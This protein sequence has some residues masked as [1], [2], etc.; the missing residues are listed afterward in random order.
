MATIKWDEEGKKLYEAGTSKGVLFV[1]DGAS[2]WKTGVPWNG[3]I[4][5][6]QN[7][8][9][10]ESNP[11]Y[12]NND[13][14]IIMTS[15]ENFKGNI[16]AYTYPDEFAECDGTKEIA[17]GVLLGQQGRIPFCLVYNTILG[18]DILG[19]DYGEKMHFIYNAK[20]ATSN[21][22]YSTINNDLDALTF[23]WEFDTTPVKNTK[24]KPTA[25]V[26]LNLT[27]ISEN[28]KKAIMNKVYGTQTEDP[29]MP[30]IDE[31]VELAKTV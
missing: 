29:K 4:A 14:Y 10:A 1:S 25:I 26:T 24:G 17:P 23:S 16:E 11:I 21:K 20:A 3:L 19:N 18:N 12:A 13:K 27:K 28:A 2:G 30:T 22:D 15:R 9:G 8:E 6:K 5:V 7:P 31:L